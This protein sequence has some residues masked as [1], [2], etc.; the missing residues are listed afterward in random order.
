MRYELKYYVE[1]KDFI[2]CLAVINEH[3]AS[4]NQSFDARVVNNIYLDSPDLASWHESQYGFPTRRKYR[5]RWYGDWDL[6]HNPVLEIKEKENQVG[7]KTTFPVSNF[8]LAFL[9]DETERI[10]DTFGLPPHLYPT[11]TNCYSRMYYES[12]CGTF[13]ITLDHN[14]M[15][16]SNYCGNLRP[17]ATSHWAIMELKYE[18][19]ADDNADWIRQFIPFRR[20][21]FSKYVAS[22]EV[23]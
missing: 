4:F 18:Q 11:S 12:H 23:I 6:V 16:G 8:D 19:D 22:F 17:S 1:E 21:K 13:R 5:I 10:K 7:T 9:N 15:Y 2:Q 14:L 3:P 20:S